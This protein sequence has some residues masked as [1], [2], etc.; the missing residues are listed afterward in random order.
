MN[1]FIYKYDLFTMNVMGMGEKPRNIYK[2]QG[3]IPRLVALP[4]PP[5]YKIGDRLFS[6][7]KNR[8]QAGPT[9]GGAGILVYRAKKI[10]GWAWYG[11]ILPGNMIFIHMNVQDLQ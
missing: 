4:S 11:W 5:V 3:K 7:R 2:N 9:L 6:G 8:K 1:D 10:K